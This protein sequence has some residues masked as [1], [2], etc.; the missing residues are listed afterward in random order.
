MPCECG[1]IFQS[2]HR[3]QRRDLRRYPI[4]R[5][6][7]SLYPPPMSLTRL[8]AKVFRVRPAEVFQEGDDIINA[9]PLRPASVRLRGLQGHTFIF[10]TEILR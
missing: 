6:F 3:H 1:G 8:T 7:L 4:C 2:K 10:W 5:L 9:A